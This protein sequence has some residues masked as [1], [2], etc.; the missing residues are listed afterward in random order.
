[1]KLFRQWTWRSNLELN[2]LAFC[3]AFLLSLSGPVLAQDT[4]I[5]SHREI[6]HPVYAKEGMVVS[7][8]ALATRA[9]VEILKA[10]GT[11][12]DAAV[13]VGLALRRMNDR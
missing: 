10:G 6:F 8:E 7:Q 9:G 3:W 11:A 5:L 13:G 2:L 1:M 12:I 4:P